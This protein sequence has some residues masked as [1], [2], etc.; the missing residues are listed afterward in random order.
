MNPF[1]D[2][3]AHHPSLLAPHNLLT[4]D[5]QDELFSLLNQPDLPDTAMTAEMADGYLT[6][7]AIGPHPVDTAQWLEAIFGQAS[8]PACARPAQKDRLLHLLLCRWRD[9]VHAFNAASAPGLFQPMIGSVQDDE[10]ITPCR[11]DDEG[12]RVG[13]WLG[14]DWAIGF[15][16]AVQR[17]PVWKNL[18]EDEEHWP[19][20]APVILLF[21]GHDPEAPDYQLD[22][23]DQALIK[24]VSALYG[25]S[26]YWC[27]FGQAAVAVC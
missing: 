3:I 22:D 25:I 21:Q 9:I 11:L 2:Y 6:A 16:S 1:V 27:R 15:V 14:R 8:M 26:Q 18:I 10:Y 7:C 17:D 13:E 20:M 12:R 19:L 23:D 24:L 4:E 5:E